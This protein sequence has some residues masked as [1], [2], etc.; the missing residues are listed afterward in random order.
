MTEPMKDASEDE[1]EEDL[2]LPA[3]SRKGTDDDAE[4]ASKAKREEQLRKMMEVDGKPRHAR[5]NGN[6]IAE[7]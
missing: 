2:V 1:Q 7:S 6:A 4:R 5:N 3:T